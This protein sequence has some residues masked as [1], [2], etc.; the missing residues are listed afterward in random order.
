MIIIV[1]VEREKGASSY[2]Y[3]GWAG[4]GQKKASSFTLGLV[5]E[6]L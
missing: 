5:V 2:A 4:R 3:G 6:L 1:V